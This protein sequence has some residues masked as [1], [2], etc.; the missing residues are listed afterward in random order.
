MS[1]NIEV[2]PEEALLV[3]KGLDPDALAWAPEAVDED[4]ERLLE[5][6]RA[7]HGELL[8]RLEEVETGESNH[9]AFL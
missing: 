9:C 7:L 1:A 8:K 3:H 4:S 5:K 2:T 6:T